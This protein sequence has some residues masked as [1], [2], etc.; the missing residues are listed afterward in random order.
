MGR[1]Y[2]RKT[3][4]RWTKEDLLKALLCIK[5]RKLNIPDAARQY[6]IS[7]ATLERHYPRFM[8]DGAKLDSN[9]FRKRGAKPILTKMEEDVLVKTIRDLR[10][11]RLH[12]DFQ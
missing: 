10:E 3:E 1:N 7:R 9:Q 2:K 5:S 12:C 8:L 6:G 4:E 11:Q